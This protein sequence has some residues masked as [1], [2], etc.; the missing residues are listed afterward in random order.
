MATLRTQSLPLANYPNG[1]H[2]L[3]TYD[4]PDNAT[5][6]EVHIARCTAATPTIWPNASTNIDVRPEVSIDGGPWVAEGRFT[7]DGGIYV[8][9]AGLEV[10]ETFNTIGLPAGVNRKLRASVTITGGPL[11]TQV[12]IVVKTAA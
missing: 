11:R 3:P 4:I 10:P 1:V 6:I 8:N 12:D 2:Q 9:K 5:E 7:G